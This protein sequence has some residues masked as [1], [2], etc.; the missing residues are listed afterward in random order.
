MSWCCYIPKG[1]SV[2]QDK[3]KNAW[4]KNADGGGFSYSKGRK[5]Y[6]KKGFFTFDDFYKEYSKLDNKCPRILFF[7]Y[8]ISL[9][10]EKGESL[11]QPIKINEKLV[12]AF[13]GRLTGFISNNNKTDVIQF[14]ESILSE[15]FNNKTDLV[16]SKEIGWLI[17]ESIGNSS[18]VFMSNEGKA[19]II[20]AHKGV[21][22]KSQKNVWY[23][24]TEHENP[25]YN[26]SNNYNNNNHYYYINGRYSTNNPALNSK[27]K[28]SPLSK[29]YK[30]W[31]RECYLEA[32]LLDGSVI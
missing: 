22:D 3:I 1:A 23:N 17:G 29:P 24:N 21:W 16:F 9:S 20:N 14:N 10:G 5:L 27:D 19:C 28:E 2:P 12:F 18:A 30:T 32:K 7:W 11:C 26:Y 4:D 13:E 31:L 15:F 6:I 25:K 8:G